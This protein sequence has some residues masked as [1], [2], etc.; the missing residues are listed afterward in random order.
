MKSLNFIFKFLIITLFPVLT[1]SGI[2]EED[3]NQPQHEIKI[4]LFEEIITKIG[5]KEINPDA[6]KAALTGYNK[7]EK[8][9]KISNPILTIADFSQSANKP[10]FYVIDMSNH[11]IK[12]KSLVA[13]GK[14]T[15]EEYAKN[16]ANILNSGKSSIGFYITGETY[17]GKHGYSLRLDGVEPS[18]DQARSRAIVIHGADYVSEDFIKNNGRLGRSQGCPALP[19]AV[20]KDII[21]IIKDQSCLFIYYP[22]QDYIKSSSLIK[23]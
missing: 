1:F 4:T 12:F 2:P 6:L 11:S 10:R 7:L 8:Q 9:N 13:H 23:D 16:F 15:G 21:D 14:H 18:N 19:R 5:D 3:K 22:C 17:E 20:S